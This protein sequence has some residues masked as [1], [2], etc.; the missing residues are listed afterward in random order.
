MESGRNSFSPTG[1]DDEILIKEELTSEQIF[2]EFVTQSADLLETV[3]TF[4]HLCQSL[5][6]NPRN[7]KT[8]FQSLAAR[9]T[10]WKAKNLWNK[11]EKR[12]KHSDYKN[13]PCARLKTVVIGAGPCGLRT[14]I[15]LALLGAEVIVIEKRDSFSRN[16]VLHLWPF[17]IV[18]LKSLGA[19]IFYGKFCAGSLDH[20]SIRKL[21]CILLKV[22]LILGVQVY[23][24]TSFDELLE[25]TEGHGWRVK[26]SPSH[27]DIANTDIDAIVGADGRRNLLKGFKRKEF[28]GKLAIGITVN[29]VNKNTQVEAAIEEI[30]GVAFIYN[31]QFFQELK[32][33]TGIDLENIVYYK[34]DTHYFVMTAKKR[35]LLDKGVIK[36]DNSDAYQL[37]A[38]QNVHQPSLLKYATQAV[39]FSTN[40][41]LPHH[42]FAMNHYG[43]E[44]VAM[45]DF[46]SMHAAENASRIIERKGK[47]ILMGVVGDTL[48][49]PFWPTGSGCAR[50]FLSAFDAAWAVRSLGL[51]KEPLDIIQERESILRLLAQTKP[52][53][54]LTDHQ[55]YS[56]DPSTRYPNLNARSIKKEA[57]RHL[58][59]KSNIPFR[60]IDYETMS[61]QSALPVS[62]KKQ[63]R[64]SNIDAFSLLRWC[65]EQTKAYP[66]VKIVDLAISWKSGLGFCAIIN[67]YRPDLLNFFELD[68]DDAEKNCQLAFDIADEHLGIPPKTS[69]KDF[70]SSAV[71]DRLTVISYLS[72]FYDAF[73]GELPETDEV[74]GE[75]S[76][77]PRVL[78]WNTLRTFA[79]VGTNTKSK[80]PSPGP[81][82]PRKSPL[83]ANKN[84]IIARLSRKSKKKTRNMQSRKTKERSDNKENKAAVGNKNLKRFDGQKGGKLLEKKALLED[85]SDVNSSPEHQPYLQKQK[86]VEKPLKILQP[87]ANQQKNEA[88]LPSIQDESRPRNDSG[89]SVFVITGVQTGESETDVIQNQSKRTSKINMLAESV[90]GVPTKQAV[91]EAEATLSESELCFFCKR[92]VY[93]LERMSAEGLFFHR[94]CFRCNVCKCNL[95]LGNYAFDA[96]D[97]DDGKNGSFYCKMHFNRILY[98]KPKAVTDEQKEAVASPGRSRRARPVTQIIQPS[99]LQKTFPE[100]IAPEESSLPGEIPRDRSHTAM[101]T[102]VSDINDLKERSSSPYDKFEAKTLV[103]HPS[104]TRMQ[105]KNLSPSKAYPPS[106]KIQHAVSTPALQKL[107]NE[108][109]EFGEDLRRR[110]E[111]KDESN[112]RRKH[113]RKLQPSMELRKSI[114]RDLLSDE[115]IV[116]GQP[117]SPKFKKRLELDEDFKKEDAGMKLRPVSVN[118]DIGDEVEESTG[119]DKLEDGKVKPKKKK[120]VL[121]KKKPKKTAE[122]VIP[123][124][125]DLLSSPEEKKAPVNIPYA[126]GEDVREKRS[127]VSSI[128]EVSDKGTTSEVPAS[129]ADKEKLPKGKADMANEGD[130]PVYLEILPHDTERDVEMPGISLDKKKK[131]VVKSKKEI[132]KEKKELKKEKKKSKIK[133]KKEAKREK[134]KTKK[135]KKSNSDNESDWVVVDFN[136]GSNEC[137]VI[138]G[139]RERLSTDDSEASDVEKQT[140]KKDKLFSSILGTKPKAVQKTPEEQKEEERKQKR[141]EMK[142][143]QQAAN[144]RRLKRLWEAQSIQRK[145][146]EVEVKQVEL[147]ERA[148]TLERKLRRPYL[149]PE[150]EKT[151]MLD[152]FQIVNDKNVL[153]RFESELV[154]QANSIQLEDRQARLESDIRELLTSDHPNPDDQEWIQVLTKELVDTVEERNNLVEMLE[155]DRLRELE[156]D[157]NFHDLLACKAEELGMDRLI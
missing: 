77:K 1:D 106:T 99:S 128:A 88:A 135:E 150:E 33:K 152:W 90:F 74:D 100:I 112:Q 22:C 16:N 2:S 39:D 27:A 92:R 55:K 42:E 141:K 115:V 10:F 15:E 17:L 78:F 9:L 61:K 95:L 54:M 149:K 96:D 136:P 151:L 131:E 59:D 146:N 64:E 129:V 57:V 154:I 89:E 65:Q 60:T 79:V 12:A 18:D 5:D 108:D 156:E 48:I 148:K 29:F 30:S 86:E 116:P 56:I 34:D 71:P 81:E 124:E 102:R 23:A 38:P 103:R 14:A 6:I 110:A 66:G 53:N 84:T 32:D 122:D 111:L 126:L 137:H 73:K 118:I 4:H 130:E 83:K 70:T 98:K 142:K 132:E 36:E 91:A 147:D 107:L 37:L 144:E 43:K 121:K 155:E 25:P 76:K 85:E 63:E 117:S 7:Y 20:I 87:M 31:Q 8:V 153:L 143:I 139:P 51:G 47:R 49:E 28:R 97:D 52:G 140:P 104:L 3:Q 109:N 94:Q 35:S 40:Y 138:D 120:F 105:S 93:V 82:S 80:L 69:G 113:L 157:K 13:K 123:E 21:Q 24:Q 119:K 62:P 101:E 19:K 125:K 75:V 67:R 114:E 133:E 41:K 11:I 58:Y 68:D 50:G 45:F 44:D 145:L 46:T 134:K 127:L 72:L 26:T